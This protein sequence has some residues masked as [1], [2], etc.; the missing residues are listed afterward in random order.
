MAALWRIEMEVD[1]KMTKPH[2]LSIVFVYMVACDEIDPVVDGKL[3]PCSERCISDPSAHCVSIDGTCKNGA[4]CSSGLTCTTIDQNTTCHSQFDDGLQCRPHGFSRLLLQ[5]EFGVGGMPIS[6]DQAGVSPGVVWQAPRNAEFVAC[7]LFS[8]NPSFEV[9]GLSPTGRHELKKIVN[10]EQCVLLFGAA[11][12]SQ[13]AF[14]LVEENV[15]HESP[16]C[17]QPEA[18]ERVVNDLAVA[19]WAYDT[20]SILA[21]SDL[22]HVPGSLLPGLSVIPHDSACMIHPDGSSCY[23]QAEDRFGVCLGGVC[24]SRCRTRVDCVTAGPTSPD[25]PCAWSCLE[26][27]GNALGACVPN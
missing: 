17:E 27:S 20:T 4:D 1:I 21:A 26:V 9:I 24:R 8:C 2:L 10:F 23:E 15:Y 18:A 19:C 14:A 22:V 7:A 25:D 3:Q 5:I 6:L 13:S 12:A 16:R 11:P